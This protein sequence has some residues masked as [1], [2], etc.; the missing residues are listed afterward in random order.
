MSTSAYYKARLEALQKMHVELKLQAPQPSAKDNIYN[1]HC[2][3]QW[4]Q[5]SDSNNHIT[6]ALKSHVREVMQIYQHHKE[7]R[8]YDSRVWNAFDQALIPWTLSHPKDRPNV[9]T[10]KH[11]CALQKMIYNKNEFRKRDN[12]A[13]LSST[14]VPRLQ[15]LFQFIHNEYNAD[16]G[17][18]TRS[19]LLWLA[20]LLMRELTLIDA[21]HWDRCTMTNLC[22]M[23]YL[24]MPVLAGCP[25]GVD[26]HLM[27]AI[28]N[29]S[30]TMHDECSSELALYDQFQSSMNIWVSSLIWISLPWTIVPADT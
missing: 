27:N 24:F 7:Y 4:N 8:F 2:E 15:A 11:Y 29:L 30:A 17:T 12:D 26:Q 3:M 16:D 18:L 5:L 10:V 23:Q 22:M 6:T 1:M 9:W 13:C 28:T 19:K 25:L 14:I 21:F 20:V